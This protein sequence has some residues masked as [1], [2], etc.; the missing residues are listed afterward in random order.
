[1]VQARIMVP[2]VEETRNMKTFCVDSLTT[3]YTRASTSRAT[4][5]I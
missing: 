4:V 2:T 1:M 5:C 3:Y